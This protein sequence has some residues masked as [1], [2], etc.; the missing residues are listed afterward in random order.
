MVV[1][2]QTR[3]KLTSVL[4]AVADTRR[5]SADVV[6][7]S[8]PEGLL[9]KVE[10]I[11][12][13]IGS[14]ADEKVSDLTVQPEEPGTRSTTNIQHVKLQWSV[15]CAWGGVQGEVRLNIIYLPLFYRIQ[16]KGFLNLPR[17]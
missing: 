6:D 17:V 12:S 8:I 15:V 5:V 14:R 3:L 10:D 9:M 7:A 1:V 16:E 11:L 13:R 2:H 4:V